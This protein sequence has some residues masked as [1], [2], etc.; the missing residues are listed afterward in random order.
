MAHVLGAVDDAQ[1]ALAVDEARVPG[2]E[3]LALEGVGGGLGILQVLLEHRG[4]LDQ[5]LAAVGKLEF[6]PRHRAAVG[7]RPH[8]VRRRHG[9][10]DAGLGHGVELLEVDPQRPEEVEDLRP[11]RLARGVGH[12]HP[13]Q[14]QVV[15]QRPVD[16]Q[17]PQREQQALRRARRAAL[18]AL[19]LDAVGQA[20][21]VVEQLALDPARVLHADHDRGE[22]VLAD[23]RRGEEV[24]GPDLAQVVQ[25]RVGAL[26]AV[27][28]EAA[29]DGHAEGVEEVAHPGHGQVGHAGGVGLEPLVLDDAA[30]SLDQVVLAQHHAL[31]PAGRAGGVADH[32]QVVGL[33][34]GDL[35]LQVARMLPP[36]TPPKLLHR[37]VA[38]QVVLLV[39]A[40]AARVLIDHVLQ[41]RAGRL[42]ADHLVRL[43]L[44]LHQGEAG[45]GVVH[46]ELHL[47]LDGVLV[48]RH[49]H[50]AQA[51]GGHHAPV[52]L[53][54]V[55]PH[56]ADAV[57]AA[58]AHRREPVRQV[59]HLLG[60][61]AP[62]VGLPDA[63]V[64]L[65][66]G[67]PVAQIAGIFHEQRGEGRRPAVRAGSLHGF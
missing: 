52:E 28:R 12:A 6:H 25:H 32:G 45:L 31:G 55:V 54:A 8:L 41:Q 64:L 36:E 5:H 9:D 63:V 26:G 46:D 42:D 21:E 67:N 47:A 40:Q 20:D 11:D 22:Q 15:Q 61:F 59:A 29:H 14:P 19:L 2:A 3:V 27:H 38:L 48:Q 37:L 65:P 24:V 51:L 17:P 49:R 57:A 13:A 18:G 58:E 35:L 53:R 60:G 10:E 39:V 16:Q 43:L 7:V 56:D 50:A 62:S 44:V 23:A 66:D 4:A 1:V 33:P 30:R 34:L